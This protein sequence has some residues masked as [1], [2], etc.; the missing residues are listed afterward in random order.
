MKK[1]VISYLCILSLF[2]TGCSDIVSLLGQGKNANTQS[3]DMEDAEYVS[4]GIYPMELPLPESWYVTDATNFDLQISNDLFNVSFYGYLAEDIRNYDAP[5]DVFQEQNQ[6][7]MDKRDNVT[8]LQDYKTE[9][10]SDRIIH[11]E[12]YS[13]ERDGIENYYAFYFVEFKNSEAGVWILI[14]SLPSLFDYYQDS[15]EKIVLS[16][17]MKDEI[18]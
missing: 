1:L 11:S 4:L 7:L 8:Q 16:V 6:S 2:L 14:T 3:T 15:L 12:I 10:L 18:Y 17:K 5:K 13:A 9:E